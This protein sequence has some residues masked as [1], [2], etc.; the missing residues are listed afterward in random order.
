MQL[1][2]RQKESRSRGAVN[3]SKEISGVEGLI[4]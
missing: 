3:L 4:N 2:V 1:K